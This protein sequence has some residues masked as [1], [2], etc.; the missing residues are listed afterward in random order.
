MKSNTHRQVFDLL[1]MHG[2]MG[3]KLMER[4][5]SAESSAKGS[6]APVVS[7]LPDNS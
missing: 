7:R 3:V 1:H 4:D 5:K 6:K 2:E